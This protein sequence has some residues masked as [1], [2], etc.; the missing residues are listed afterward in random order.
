MTLQIREGRLSVEDARAI[1]IARA[2]ALRHRDHVKGS[3][4]R[5]QVE[6]LKGRDAT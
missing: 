3:L 2:R 4:L 6:E 5:R 1:V